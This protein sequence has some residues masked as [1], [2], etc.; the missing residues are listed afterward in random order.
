MKKLT[1]ADIWPNPVY[2][3]TRDEFRATLVKAK[4]PRRVEIGDSVT[5]IFENRD[6][7]KFQIQEMLR[8]EG[9]TSPEGVQ[10]EIDVYNG[11][12]SGD[13]ELSA[14]LMIDVTEEARIPVM[15][16]RLVGI[17]ETLWLCFEGREVRARFEEGRSDG[18]RVSAVQFVRFPL[19]PADREAFERAREATLELRHPAYRASA[20]LGPETLAS[21]RQDLAG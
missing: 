12:V 4:A 3:R 11:L 1:R 18:A 6:T 8:V 14:T 5:L 16:N 20:R 7:V 2:E 17:E 9:I 21:L 13:G 10:A 19:G 15:L